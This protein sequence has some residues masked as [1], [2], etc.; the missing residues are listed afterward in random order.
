MDTY[1][2]SSTAGLNGINQDTMDDH[3]HTS[4][5]Y[6]FPINDERSLYKP[7]MVIRTPKIRIKSIRRY[8]ILP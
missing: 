3:I 1:I 2:I 8:T 6:G 4:L 7:N 5:I